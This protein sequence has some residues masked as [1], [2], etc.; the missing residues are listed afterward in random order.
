[1][2]VIFPIVGILLPL[3]WIVIVVGAIKWGL[4]LVNSANGQTS[5]ARQRSDAIT[6]PQVSGRPA[7]AVKTQTAAKPKEATAA[8][9]PNV[10]QKT[11][12]AAAKPKAPAA[13]GGNAVRQYSQSARSGQ[14]QAAT[15]A[16]YA[17]L[18]S[19]LQEDRKH[20]WLARQK[21]EEARIARHNLLDLGASHGAACAADE[22]KKSHRHDPRGV[23]GR[24]D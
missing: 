15:R 8:A 14:K 4:K 16:G 12:A 6:V 3:L 17:S 11:T 13:K 23:V 2:S 1:M 21:A 18:A 22:I 7:G 10:Q 19:I 5:P 24:K 9:K 20:D